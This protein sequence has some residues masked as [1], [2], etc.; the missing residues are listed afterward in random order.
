MNTLATT[1]TTAT[2]STNPQNEKKD[3]LGKDD[4]LRIFITQLKNQD[5][6]QPLEDKDFIAQMAQFS[7]LEQITNMANEM[8]G[9]N[10][11]LSQQNS[12]GSLSNLIGKIGHWKND[13]G[14]ELSG[15]ITSVLMKAGEYYATIDS[16]EVPIYQLFQVESGV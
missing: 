5:P 11:F 12:L 1:S 14:T 9:I 8:A 6:L 10:Q 15:E 13:E 7:S 4:F 2:T 3:I 16:Q